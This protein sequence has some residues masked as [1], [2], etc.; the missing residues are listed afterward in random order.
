LD[1]QRLVEAEFGDPLFALLGGH[2]VEEEH[3]GRV[4][5]DHSEQNEQDGK[6]RPEGEHQ[7]NESPDD[8]LSKAHY[9][10]TSVGSTAS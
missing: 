1:V 3:R 4:T 5:G 7:L 2:P 9:P 8:E 6:E 10:V